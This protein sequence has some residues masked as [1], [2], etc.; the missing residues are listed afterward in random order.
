[1]ADKVK[2]LRPV[3]AGTSTEPDMPQKTVVANFT[4][5]NNAA[6]IAIDNSRN[7]FVSDSA[8]HVILKYRFG[9][10]DAPAVYAG[11]YDQA[12]L[13]DGQA[14]AARFD[15]PGAIA[16]DPSGVLW[17]IDV[18]NNRIRRID[19]NANV[20]TVAA[21]TAAAGDPIAVDTSGKIF[22]VET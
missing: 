22:F 10:K 16:V 9:S 15:S 4:T 5:L 6:G 19:A 11:A 2:W 21:T 8:R 14:T 13:V 12:G 18:G 1:M 7:I 20:W 17:V 3:S